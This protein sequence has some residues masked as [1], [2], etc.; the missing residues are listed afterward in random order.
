MS[1]NNIFSTKTSEI[2]RDDTTRRYKHEMLFGFHDNMRYLIIYL[3]ILLTLIIVASIFYFIWRDVKI[4]R[5]N[6]DN[7]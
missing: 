4:T 3:T 5:D 1:N 2:E 6:L 7:V